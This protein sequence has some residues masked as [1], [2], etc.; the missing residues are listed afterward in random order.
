MDHTR[1]TR[2][3]VAIESHS[4]TYPGERDNP[5]GHEGY[6]IWCTSSS[7]K[8]GWIPEQFLDITDGTATALVDCD[9]IELTVAEGDRLMGGEPV[10][11]W[12]WCVTEEDDAGWVP[13]DKLR[14]A[15]DDE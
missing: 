1:T 7:G 12:V 2:P 5:G 14:P 15:S 3:L 4:R 8:S 10:N 6:W 9:A 11:G 13:E